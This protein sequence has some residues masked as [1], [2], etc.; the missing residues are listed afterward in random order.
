M[1]SYYVSQARAA[2]SSSPY[3]PL[4]R[5]LSPTFRVSA[6]RNT[7]VRFLFTTFVF[8][9]RSDHPII[10][11]YNSIIIHILSTNVVLHLFS[12]LSSF[13]HYKY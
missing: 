9:V 4:L 8:L 3:P 10:A 11:D 12:N 7:C 13:K 5:S 6:L 1:S 2:H